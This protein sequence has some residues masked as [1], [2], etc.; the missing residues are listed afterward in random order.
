MYDVIYFLT[1]VIKNA[2]LTNKIFQLLLKADAKNTF[3]VWH[4]QN[5]TPFIANFGSIRMEK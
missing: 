4:S 5:M 3:K 2:I 1:L